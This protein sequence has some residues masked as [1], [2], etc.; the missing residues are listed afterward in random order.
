MSIGS[1]TVRS[2]ACVMALAFAAACSDD[3]VQTPA[4]DSG[5]LVETG[6]AYHLDLNSHGLPFESLAASASCSVGGGLEQAVLP[7]GFVATPVAKEGTGYLDQADQNTQ[8][9][10][11]WESGRFLYRAHETG[12][13]AA[14][15]VTDLV[16]GQSRIVA[17]RADWERFDGILWTPWGTV[18]SSEESSPSAQ[19][20]P[21]YPNSV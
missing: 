6:L 7:A 13:N 11:G 15:S 9:E 10:S 19:K 5:T 12:S 4:N 20:D 1:V 3:N 2:A 16:T 18:L 8:N 17:Q 21:E 14:V